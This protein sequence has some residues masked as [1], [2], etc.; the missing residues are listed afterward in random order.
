MK[1]RMEFTEEQ[2][3]ELR[4]CTQN[5]KGSLLNNQVIAHLRANLQQMLEEWWR[6]RY[7]QHRVEVAVER[8]GHDGLDIT[9]L[10][11]E[12]EAEKVKEEHLLKQFAESQPRTRTEELES[13]VG[14]WKLASGLMDSTGD[15]DG[16]T[17][18]IAKEYWENL[19]RRYDRLCKIAIDVAKRYNSTTEYGTEIDMEEVIERLNEQ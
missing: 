8:S 15:P 9:F 12:T 2:A 14:E 19:E 6:R 17:P 10:R 4:A 7:I 11:E 3:H 18:K 13:E 1:R 16:I 5:F